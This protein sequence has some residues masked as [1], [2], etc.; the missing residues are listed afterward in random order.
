MKK[1]KQLR[2]CTM[3]LLAEQSNTAAA[4]AVFV[5]VTAQR[6]KYKSNSDKVW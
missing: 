1:T 6:A 2:K 4:K 3:I 5:S